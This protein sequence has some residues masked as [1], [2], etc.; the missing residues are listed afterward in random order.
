MSAARDGKRINPIDPVYSWMRHDLVLSRY[1]ILTIAIAI[2]ALVAVGS[3]LYSNIQ[4]DKVIADL[5][6]NKTMIG[7]PN[8]DG[9]FVSTSTTPDYV[10]LRFAR[11]FVDN[12]F[13]YTP[14]GAAQNL[15]EARHMMDPS[16]AITYAQFFDDTLALVNKDH[17]TQLYQVQRYQMPEPTADGYVVHFQGVLHQL[18]GQEEITAP[19]TVPITVWLKRVPFTRTTPEGLMVIAVSDKPQAQ[20][21]GASP[22]VAQDA[23]T[24]PSQPTTGR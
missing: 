19:K 20:P 21:A 18:A 2:I 22:A 9:V 23:P 17:L 8:K 12:F 5:S 16:L 14:D 6:K 24:M 3:L 7:F 13:N 10:V 11:L 15:D 4:K 1:Q